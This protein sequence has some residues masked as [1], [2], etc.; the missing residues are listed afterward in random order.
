MTSLETIRDESHLRQTVAGAAPVLVD[1]WAP[2][3]GPC[4]M[5]APV[6]AELAS[7]LDGRVRVAKVNV[8]ELPGAAVELGVQGIPT[9][10][11][12]RDGREVDRMV[13]AVP[14]AVLRRWLDERAS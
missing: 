6:L 7:E 10:V 5:V 8:D 13:G 3:C 11:L 12:F 2:W 9:L 14:K 4:R 1:F